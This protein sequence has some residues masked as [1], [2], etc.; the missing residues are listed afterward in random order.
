MAVTENRRPRAPSLLDALLPVVVLMLGASPLLVAQTAPTVDQILSLKRA[1]TPEISPDG[2][3]IVFVGSGEP[4]RLY[5]RSLDQ[6]D[7]RPL[8]GTEGANSPFF[9]PGPP[10]MKQPMP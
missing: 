9:S 5:A 2:R 3:L 1:G 4:R 7:P 6:V 10:S 8:A